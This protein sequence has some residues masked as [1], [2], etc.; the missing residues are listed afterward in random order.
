[1]NKA[2]RYIILAVLGALILVGIAA[3][4]LAGKSNR[5]PLKCKGL[6]VVILDSL[7]ND[8]VSRADIKQILDKEYGTY[9][10]ETIDSLDLCRIEKIVDGRTAVH[11]S[12]AYVTKDGRL[13][14]EVTQRRPVVRFQKEDGGFYA[15]MDGYVFPLQSSYASHVQIVDGNIPV[16]AKSGHKGEITDPQEKIWFDR[17]MTVVRFL[18]TDPA[19]KEKIVQI[20]VDNGGE[21]TLVP[22]EGREIFIFGQPVNIE[23]KFSRL[24]KYYTTILPAKAEEKYKTVNV[25]YD[26]QIVCRK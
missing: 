12:E 8:F 6:E 18:E 1:M 24:T 21:L 10:G 22:R 16:N 15:D 26:G 25:K 23:D 4:V 19:W 17:I 9:I 20:H 7:E 2:V 3:A 11:T 13:H 5:E 14:I